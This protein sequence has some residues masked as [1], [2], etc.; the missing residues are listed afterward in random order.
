MKVVS[1]FDGMSCGQIALQEIAD[2]FNVSKSTIS[3]VINK[4]SWEHV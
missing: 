2:I 3:S 4:K 1:L